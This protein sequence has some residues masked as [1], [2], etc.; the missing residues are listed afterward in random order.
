MEAKVARPLFM[1]NKD[2]YYFDRKAWR[3]KLT[4]D[5]PPEAVESYKKFYEELKKGR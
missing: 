1:D 5:A 4:E 3:Y 2:W